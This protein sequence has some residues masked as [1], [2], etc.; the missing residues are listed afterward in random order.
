[1]NRIHA[2]DVKKR[3]LIQIADHNVPRLAQ[4]ALN[5]DANGVGCNLPLDDVSIFSSAFCTFKI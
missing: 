1:M 2:V 5:T 3:P 4:I